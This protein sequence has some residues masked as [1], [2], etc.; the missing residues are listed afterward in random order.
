MGIF[1]KILEWKEERE[2]CLWRKWVGRKIVCVCVCVWERERER[3]RGVGFQETGGKDKSRKVSRLGDSHSL[4]VAHRGGKSLRSL[5]SVFWVLWTLRTGT[6]CFNKHSCAPHVAHE[7]QSCQFWMACA[8]WDKGFQW[9][10][11]SSHWRGLWGALMLC[12][13][14]EALHIS[15]GCGCKRR[16][17][18]FVKM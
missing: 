13:F 15:G 2:K 4:R 8:P 17:E 11:Q 7:K 5:H 9:W 1:L 14:L 6:H 16:I 12:R 10:A 18:R 3:E